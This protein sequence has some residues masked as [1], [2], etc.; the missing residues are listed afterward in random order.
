MIFINYSWSVNL[1]TNQKETI[2]HERRNTT[3]NNKNTEYT[4]YRKKHKKLALK[5]YYCSAP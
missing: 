1:K 3:Q 2:I 5:E 4:K